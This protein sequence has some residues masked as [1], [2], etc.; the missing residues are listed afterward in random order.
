M[1]TADER[2]RASET[3]KAN[4]TMIYLNDVDIVV[5]RVFILLRFDTE[6]WMCDVFPFFL[7]EK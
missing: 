6:M 2:Q 3:H 5:G 1:L 7:V 4:P